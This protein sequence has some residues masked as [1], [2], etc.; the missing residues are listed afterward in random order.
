MQDLSVEDIL[1]IFRRRR[2]LF[3]AT[4][5]AVLALVV[6]F[7][8]NWSHYRATATVQIEQPVVNTEA[9]GDRP[10]ALADRRISQ[11]Q[12]K[13]TST[14]S[15]SRII[16]DLN[17]Y[18]K[19]NRKISADK[20]TAMMRDKIKLTF[21]SSEVSN[22]TAAQ[23]ESVDQLSAIA[24]TLRFDYHD[25]ALTKKTLDALVQNFLLEEANERQRKSKETTAF[26]DAQLAK[27]SATI[28]AQEEKIA[29][30]RAQYGESGSSAVLFNQQASL[31]N[32]MNLQT[33]ESQMSAAQATISSLRSQLAST[34]AYTSSDGKQ[35]RGRGQLGALKAEY[36]ALTTRY[37]A[38]H[39]DVV[40]LR[41]QIRTASAGV[42]PQAVALAQDADNPVYVQLKAQLSAEQAQYNALAGQAAAVRQQQA[43]YDREIAKNPMVEQEMS[44]LTLDL[45]N[46]KERYSALKEKKLTAEMNEKLENGENSERLKILSPAQLPEGTTPKRK[47]LILGGL[48]LALLSAVGVV[49]VIEALSQSV[50]GANHLAAIV[51]VAPLVSIPCLHA[52]S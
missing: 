11:I 49:I 6:L 28:K 8:L 30:F 31:S 34:P 14:E 32:A 38:E 43:K 23:R 18:P 24:F 29:A 52:K 37:G 45:S 42:A 25:P 4:F 19:I 1:A 50:R 17:L 3:L 16:R 13:I 33:I 47:L 5:A 7:A 48:F 36:A 41:E 12:Q 35:L 51:G 46:A 27:L 39:P 22:P 40:K 44:Q 10:M 21:I 9:A 15:L 2:A 20:L 26:L